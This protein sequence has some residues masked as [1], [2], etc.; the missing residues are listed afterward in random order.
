VIQRRQAIIGASAALAMTGS[1]AFAQAKTEITLSRQPGIIYLATHGI[2]KQQL[3]EK[4]AAAFGVKGVTAKWVSF[5]N[6]G[7]QQDALLSGNVDVINTG[8]GPL[9][10][11]WDRTRGGV[12]GIVASSALPLMLITRDPRIQSLTDFGEGD[13]IAVPTVRVST[14]AILLQIAAVQQFGPANWGRFDALTIQMGHPDAYIMMKNAM[15]EVKSHFAAP[16]FQ[17]YELASVAGA[18]RIASSAEIM[19]GP[20]SQGQFMTSTKFADANPALI[21]AIRAAA[22]EAKAFIETQTPAAVDIY[23]EITGDKTPAAEILDLL[24]QPG[25]MEWSLQPQ[26]TLKFAE[27]LNL[28]GSLKSR[29]TSFKDYYLPIAHDLPGN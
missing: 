21:R 24:A 15:H 2:E 9:L 23:R 14:Q 16:P 27:H 7:A 5:S 4:H 11:M 26:G 13:K 8:T 20:L 19:G 29:P 10:L 12:K 17:H 1:R 22:E 28:V 6:G 3:I 25:M 18:R